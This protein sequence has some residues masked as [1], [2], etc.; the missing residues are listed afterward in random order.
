MEFDCLGVNYLCSRKS[1]TDRRRESQIRRHLPCLDSTKNQ[2]PE[3]TYNSYTKAERNIG[4][5]IKKKP[6]SK[7]EGNSNPLYYF[8]LDISIDR[9]AW[10]A[11]VHG[12]A[13]SQTRLSDKHTTFF[14]VLLFFTASRITDFMS[15]I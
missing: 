2:Y 14:N 8:C 15:N 6:S 11:S 13:K 3:H 4:N 7:G 5:T 1:T 9:G 10:R 12:V